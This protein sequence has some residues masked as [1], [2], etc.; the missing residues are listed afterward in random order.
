MYILHL[1][2]P[3]QSVVFNMEGG[4]LCFYR[5]RILLSWSILTH[6]VIGKV[7]ELGQTTTHRTN[8]MLRVSLDKLILVSASC[9]IQGTLPDPLQPST[10]PLLGHILQHYFLWTN[11]N[12][13]LSTTPTSSRRFAP[14]GLPH[15][16]LVRISELFLT[17]CGG[18]R[19]SSSG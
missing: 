13:I 5:L 17:W 3:L 11:C 8:S 16:N 10:D 12:S 6:L 9:G 1:P 14:S 19:H 18:P 4:K 15:Q 2:T 7:R